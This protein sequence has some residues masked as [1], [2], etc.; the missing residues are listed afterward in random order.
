MTH[1]FSAGLLVVGGM[2]AVG[3]AMCLLLLKPETASGK[4]HA[5]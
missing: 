5:S 1:S 3:A 2:A 4:E